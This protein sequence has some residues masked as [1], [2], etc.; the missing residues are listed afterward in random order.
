MHANEDIDAFGMIIALMLAKCE[1]E[2]PFFHFDVEWIKFIIIIL[3]NSRVVW[4]CLVERH[5]TY[6]SWKSPSRNDEMIIIMIVMHTETKLMNLYGL[7]FRILF[8]L[9]IYSFVFFSHYTM[10]VVQYGQN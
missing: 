6:T 3:Y 8:Y 9:F 7:S 2:S 1:N 10:Y 4:W 5:S